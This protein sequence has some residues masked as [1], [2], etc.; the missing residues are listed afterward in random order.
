MNVATRRRTVA[1]QR[2]KITE[3]RQ[4]LEELEQLPFSEETNREINLAYYRIEVCEERIRK[5]TCRYP[6]DQRKYATLYK[7]AI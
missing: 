2:K 6:V 4:K 3:L 5:L 1:A 7:L